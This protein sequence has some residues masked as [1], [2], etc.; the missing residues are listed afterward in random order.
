M[1]RTTFSGPV[2]SPGGFIG[3][4]LGGNT[5]FTGTFFYVNPATGADGNDGLTPATAVQ[6]ITT[7]FNKCTSGNNDV[8]YLIGDGTT[9]GTARI[10]STLTWNKNATHLIG[11]C[12]PVAI[13]QRARISHAAS[14]P[15][16]AFTPMVRVTG[17]GCLFSNIQIFE[18]FAA[19]TAVVTWEDQ[20]NRNYYSNVQ[21]AGMGNAT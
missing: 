15:T 11:V 20:G 9:A 17:N 16:T 19:D 5:I 6:S 14:A 21:F 4:V 8:V 7:A 10:S 2:V 1:A 12:S 3:P 18:G 13:S